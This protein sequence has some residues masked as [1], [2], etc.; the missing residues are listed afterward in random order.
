[1]LSYLFNRR[2][3]AISREFDVAIHYLLHDAENLI[4]LLKQMYKDKWSGFVDDI[5]N[6]ARPLRGSDRRNR[7]F[8]ATVIQKPRPSETRCGHH[9]H[10]RQQPCEP[11]EP[12]ADHWSGLLLPVFGR[13]RRRGARET[14]GDMGE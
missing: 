14:L 3:R 7:D 1:M 4:P 2:K 13:A 5:V 11:A 10:R 9:V 8:S 12:S 6:G